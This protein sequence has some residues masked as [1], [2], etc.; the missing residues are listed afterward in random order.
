[1]LFQGQ[2][3]LRDK[4]FQDTRQIDWSRADQYAGIVKLYSDL[5]RLR[6]NQ[7]GWSAGL[8]GQHCEVFHINDQEK[9]IAFR[10][11]KET[12]ANDDVIVV[13]NFAEGR[14][15][16]YRL[17][18]PSPGLW[19]LRFNSDCD[20]YHIHMDDTIVGDVEA[21]GEP[22]DGYHQS[23]IVSIGA[24]SCLIYTKK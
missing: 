2:E 7:D 21:N 5:I 17:G 24:Y 18:F 9:V 19:T 20:I 16:P 13:M 22:R 12:E 23:A 4:W 14:R 10:R 6:R 11:W 1:M 15:N 3:F 8:S